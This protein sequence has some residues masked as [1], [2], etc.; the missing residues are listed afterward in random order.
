MGARQS[1]QTFSL[2]RAG[3]VTWHHQSPH[4]LL[5]SRG[6]LQAR[7]LT[8]SFTPATMRTFFVFFNTFFH[9]F[10]FTFSFAYSLLGRMK[11]KILASVSLTR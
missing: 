11:S 7:A 6:V 10:F 2:V 1:N 3:T 4:S 9:C 5:S 8:E